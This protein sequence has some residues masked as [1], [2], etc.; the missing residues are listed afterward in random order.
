MQIPRFGYCPPRYGFGQI[1]DEV[2]TFGDF[3]SNFCFDTP[4]VN[5]YKI[6]ELRIQTADLRVNATRDLLLAALTECFRAT[7]PC[8]AITMDPYWTLGENGTLCK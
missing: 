4:C 5:F 3:N 7:V 1:Y 8:E 2:K 6:L